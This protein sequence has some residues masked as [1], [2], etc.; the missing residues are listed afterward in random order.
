M[1]LD[2]SSETKYLYA[3]V[4]VGKAFFNIGTGLEARQ[5]FGFCKI[6][7]TGKYVGV[8]YPVSTEEVIFL[9]ADGKLDFILPDSTYDS[10]G[11]KYV[12]GISVGNREWFW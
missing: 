10:P 5:N 4:S 7:V 8:V 1:L 12:N 2:D 6:G 11:L 9:N 3:D